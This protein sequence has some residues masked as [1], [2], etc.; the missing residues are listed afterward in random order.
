MRKRALIFH[1]FVLCFSVAHADQD[2]P[3]LQVQPRLSERI[4][5]EA[6]TERET[7]NR[8]F[9]PI[10]IS[11]AITFVAGATADMNRSVG[12]TQNSQGFYGWSGTGPSKSTMTPDD[13]SRAAYLTEATGVAWF[14]YAYWMSKTFLPFTTADNELSDLQAKTPA[15]K[16][17]R[18]R[19][20]EEKLN[21]MVR[22]GRIINWS[23]AL[24]NALICQNLQNSSGTTGQTMGSAC[25]LASLAPLI[26]NTNWTTV[27]KYQDEYRKKIYGPIASSALLPTGDK[28]GVVPGVA[29]TWVF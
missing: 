8:N 28:Q 12:Y 14:A 13:T 24:S 4:K 27:K 20:A 19:M 7:N 9:L 6:K 22:T 1:L 21:S 3:E 16:L 11:A 29:L 15:E 18:E 25:I 10:E 26:I 5:M 2:Y 23:F 17:V